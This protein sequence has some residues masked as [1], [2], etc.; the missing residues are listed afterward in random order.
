MAAILGLKGTGAFA[1][2]IERPYN[3]REMIL[4]LFPNG[5][6]PLTALMSKLKSEATDDSQF[7]WFEKNLPGQSFLIYS[8]LGSGDAVVVI[9]NA[10]GDT[11]LEANFKLGHL[12]LEE[13]TGEIMRVSADPTVNNTIPI[14][15]YFGEVAAAQGAVNEV[16][17]IIG[18]AYEEGASVPTAVTY[19]PD[20]Y[21]NYTQIFRNSLNLT[22]TARKTRLRT[23]DSYEES[24]R[25]ALQLHSIEMEKAFIFGHRKSTTA[26]GQPIKTTRGVVK[27][28]STNVTDMGG[29]ITESDWDDEM[30]SMFRFGSQEKLAF[31]GSTALNVI[32]QLSKNKST[33]QQV[34]GAD[35]YGMSI[36]KY[37]SPF[38][39]LYLRMHPLFNEHASWRSVM[40]VL[41]TDKIK[42]RFI[43]DTDFIKS[44]Q[45]PGDDQSIDEF[46]T[47]AGLE[48]HHENCHG[49]LT[50]ITA[51]AP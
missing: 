6:A 22:R 27:W 42:Y 32:N 46:L 50:N 20:Y 25:E 43:D 21:F 45:D 30:E 11:G 40:L 23:G 47:E 36:V 10:A 1:V 8:T 37:I 33:I 51:Y 17:T 24:K 26:N 5:E 18:S 28:L 3:W 12:L 44:R 2:N 49:Y 13:T 41:D 29:T 34:P 14:T 4:Y 19:S 38:G 7:H 9:K 15:R 39:I 35:S 48:L 31:V 16:V